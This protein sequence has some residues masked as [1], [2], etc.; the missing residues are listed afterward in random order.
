LADYYK[1]VKGKVVPIQ[2]IKIYRV[3]GGTAPLMLN[4]GTRRR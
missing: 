3:S 4:L 1:N 2:A